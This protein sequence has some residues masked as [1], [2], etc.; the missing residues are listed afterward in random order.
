MKNEILPNISSTDKKPSKNIEDLPKKRIKFLS[1]PTGEYNKLDGFPQ[2]E[3]SQ[4]DVSVGSEKAGKTLGKCKFASEKEAREYIKKQEDEGFQGVL[5]LTE[6]NKLGDAHV[7]SP[8][9]R[10]HIE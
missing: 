5:D 1:A 3:I 10:I 2:Y 4:I 8:I 7:E 6:V 9:E